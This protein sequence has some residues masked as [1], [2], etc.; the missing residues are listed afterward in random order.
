MEIGIA[1][2]DKEISECYE[3]L[4]ELRP[5]L[6]KTNFVELIR[7]LML[8]QGYRLIYLKNP[9]IKSVMGVRIGLWLHTGK[10]LEIED[11]V[12]SSTARS[13]GHGKQWLNWAKE[14]AKANNCKQVRLVSGVTRE[15]AHEFYQNNGMKFEAK[16]FSSNV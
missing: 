16:Y 15:R 13:N 14:Y 11:L 1:E 9:E 8:S 6:N 2:T 3:V 12:T 5:Q 7:E 10:Y 4:I